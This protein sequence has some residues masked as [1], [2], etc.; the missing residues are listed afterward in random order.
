[1]PFGISTIYWRTENPF[2]GSWNRFL[3]Y[4]STVADPYGELF[5]NNN[6]FRLNVI[7]LSAPLFAKLNKSDVDYKALFV[8]T[9]LC[10]Q[11]DNWYLE[12]DV[13][14]SKGSDALLVTKEESL[15]S[16]SSKLVASYLVFPTMLEY[17]FNRNW[18][19]STGLD[20]KLRIGSHTKYVYFDETGH[21]KRDKN[22]EDFYLNKFQPD[23]VAKIGWNF[24]N[25]TFKS[26]LK[27]LFREGKGP[28]ISPYS[29]GVMIAIWLE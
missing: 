5:A 22:K 7:Y 28:D 23:F 1:L 26:S 10:F 27:P 24:M 19:L 9:G 21:K 15:K 29:L 12:D 11:S 16:K 8:Y 3:W 6:Y 14:L 2:L 13:R 18:Y 17:Q 4:S 20:F 25:F